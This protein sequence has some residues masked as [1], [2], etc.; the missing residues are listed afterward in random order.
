MFIHIA[1]YKYVFCGLSYLLAYVDGKPRGAPDHR[2]DAMVTCNISEGN[3]SVG[4]EVG[5]GFRLLDLGFWNTAGLGIR[6]QQEKF[7]V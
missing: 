1:T 3:I 2:G 7:R 5:A 6:L 4:C